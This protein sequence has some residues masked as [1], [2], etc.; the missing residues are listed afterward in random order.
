MKRI[1][2]LFLLLAVLIGC[3]KKSSLSTKG[4]EKVSDRVEYRLSNE[5]FILRSGAKEIT[6]NKS[7][8][9]LEKVVVLNASLFGYFNE[10]GL[11]DRIVGVSS[12]EYIFS[13]DIQRR[14]KQGFIHSVGSEQKYDLE[15]IMAL[16]PDAIFTNYI[17]TFD[18]TYALLQKSGIKIIFLDEYLEQAPL[19]KSRYLK[20][21]GQ[22]FHQEERAE[23]LYNEIEKNYNELKKLTANLKNRPLV[24]TNEL[25][26]NQWYMPGGNS[27]FARLM[28][29]AGA[30]YLLQDDPSNAAVP[31]SLEQVTVQSQEATFWLNAGNH[32]TRS[33]LVAFNPSYRNLAVFQKG[34]IYSI[35]G[36]V[37][38]KANDYFESG[39]V[40]SD[41]LLQDYLSILHPEL[42]KGDSLRYFKRLD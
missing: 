2:F 22:L 28:K 14:I 26:G 19:D 35:A 11:N 16:K 41:F 40:R 38:G 30:K 27:Q 24:I 21:F 34:E 18:N 33:Q 4:F 39:V 31:L 17:S 7:E 36:S 6:F 37:K 12:P 8:L 10:L 32:Q 5:A 23:K 42:V 15:K 29:D 3:Q 25:Y 1:L 13:S 9:P 20:V